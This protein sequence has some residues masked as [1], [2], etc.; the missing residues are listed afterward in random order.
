MPEVI[1]KAYIDFELS[2][3]E[4]GHA[5]SLYKRLLDRSNHVKVW[6][7][8]AQFE[9]EYSSYSTESKEDEPTALEASRAVFQQAYEVLKAQGL[10]EER[11]LLL[12]AWRDVEAGIPEGGNRSHLAAVEA[13]FPRKIKMSRPVLAE[14]GVTELGGS[15]DYFDYIFPDDEKKL[16]TTTTTICMGGWSTTVLLLCCNSK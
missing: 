3:A 16:G 10:K 5:R 12:E 8:M 7:A 11:L 15:E 4:Y 1:W 9:L 2:E 13:R 6:I 14:D